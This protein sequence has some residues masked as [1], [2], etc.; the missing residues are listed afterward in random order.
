MHAT[1]FPLG[2]LAL[3][4]TIGLV[5]SLAGS[6]WAEPAQRERR[7]ARFQGWTP[8][9]DY[10][11]AGLGE[12]GTFRLTVPT[13]AGNVELALHPNAVHAHDYHGEEAHPVGARRGRGLPRVRTFAGSVEEA[14]ASFTPLPVRGGDFARLALEEN[15]RLSGLLRVDGVYYDLAADAALGDL[16]L[17]VREVTP[18]ELAGAFL[19]CGASVD[20]ALVAAAELGEATSEAVPA[21]EAAG[22]L[23]EIELG[24]EADAPFV[25]QSGG[26]DA[27]NAK[28]LSIVNSINGIYEFDLGLTN[29][30]VFQ[31]AWNGSD[32]YSSSNSDTLLNDFRNDFR[33]NVSAETDD[34]HLFSGR[35]F[36]GSTVGRAFVASTCSAYR[37]GVSQFYLQD[38]SLMRLIV[39]HE[40]GHN[41][42]GGH[43]STGLMAPSINPNVTWFSAES[44]NQI[45]TYLNR[46]SCLADVETG[47]APVLAPV[48]P[49]EVTES[50]TLALQLEASDPDGDA[51]TFSA[52][53]L[54]SGASL[55]ASGLFRWTPPRTS[56]GCGGFADRTV[57]FT[58]RDPD[59][60]RATE[61]VVISV[62]D[63]PSGAPPVLD[64]ADRSATPGQALTIPLT[65]SDADGDSVSFSAA[66]LPSGASLSASGLFRWTPS[67]GQLGRHELSFTATDCTGRSGSAGLVINVVI[68]PP[69][70]GAISAASGWKGDF[71]TISGANLAGRR[72][73][74]FFGPRKV[75]ARNVT[76]TS[77]DVRIPK[78]KKKSVGNEVAVTVMR[79]GIVSANALSFTYVDPTP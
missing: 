5:A 29:R 22:A 3:S 63:A 37:F 12:G 27:A 55:S 30:V 33:A 16:L 32:P 34:A 43:T 67:T 45:A 31:R 10:V 14:G 6:A 47:G 24:T 57:T 71:V 13:R 77:L 75:K 49:Q 38:D 68:D 44:Q 65:A 58:V 8:L 70:L 19:A 60:N 50:D 69:V 18:E 17:H 23:R 9:S 1:R 42:G 26:V 78:K 73:K 40:I 62:L 7:E 59:G 53:P 54:P 20:E 56:A 35:D 4:L 36:E 76:A 72:V 15:A 21:S 52:T 25:A 74:V 39:A 51:L 28:I 64:P 46:V 41:L 79:D 48:G 61:A 2:A 66:S 11:V